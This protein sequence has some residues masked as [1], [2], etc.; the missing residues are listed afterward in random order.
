MHVMQRLERS[1]IGSSDRK[2]AAAA[3]DLRQNGDGLQFYTPKGY[4]VT[5]IGTLCR[6]S[7]EKICSHLTCKVQILER[8]NQTV[9]SWCSQL[10]PQTIFQLTNLKFL[11]LPRR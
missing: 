10:I 3:E 1:G 7:S 8:L 6:G 5:I 2:Y 9:L 4:Q 11:A